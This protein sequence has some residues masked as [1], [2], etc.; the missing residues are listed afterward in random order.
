MIGFNY[1]YETS[2]SQCTVHERI[3]YSPLARYVIIVYN[4]LLADPRQVQSKMFWLL[5]KHWLM[6]EFHV[7]HGDVFDAIL[8]NIRHLI[9]SYAEVFDAMINRVYTSH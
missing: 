9:M 2:K 1:Y 5:I 3:M 6:T 7:C 8:N 4:A